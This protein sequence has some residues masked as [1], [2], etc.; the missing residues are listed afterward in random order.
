MRARHAASAV[1]A[2]GS[3]AAKPASSLS[4]RW[5][6]ANASFVL[7]VATSASAT[8]LRLRPTSIFAWVPGPGSAKSASRAASTAWCATNA[9]S[10]RPTMAVSLATS[11]F[12]AA[13]AP[14]SDVGLF[15]EQ[16]APVCRRSPTLTS[17]AGRA[18]P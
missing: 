15:A 18:A 10:V 1:L 16:G 17:R 5:Y 6:A 8:A 3:L 13:S 4:D 2:A 9:S 11:K 7:P 14:R 12:A